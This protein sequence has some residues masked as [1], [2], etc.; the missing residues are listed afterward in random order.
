LQPAKKI[1]I[2]KE[3]PTSRNFIISLIK[4]SFLIFLDSYFS[5]LRLSSGRRFSQSNPFHEV[6][7]KSGRGCFPI[8]KPD[9]LE[10]TNL[11]PTVRNQFFRIPFFSASSIQN[12]IPPGRSLPAGTGLPIFFCGIFYYKHFVPLGLKNYTAQYW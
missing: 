3:N 11:I 6:I 4:F 7:P 9:K 2:K 5:A 8:P 10:A 12:I 1:I